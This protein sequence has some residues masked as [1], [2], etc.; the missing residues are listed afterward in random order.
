MVAALGT[1]SVFGR[2]FCYRG[3]SLD[4]ASMRDG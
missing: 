3:T 1:V 2:H 4:D